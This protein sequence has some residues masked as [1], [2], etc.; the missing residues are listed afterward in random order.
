MSTQTAFDGAEAAGFTPA[1]NL[2]NVA[3]GTT[4]QA[5]WR[6]T[7]TGTTTWNGRYRFVYTLTPHPE[8]AANPRSPLGTQLVFA[9]T[10]LG[11]PAA[12]PPG[13]TVA[14][15][16]TLTAPA[17][18]ATHATNWQLQVPDGRR[19]SLNAP[20]TTRRIFRGGRGDDLTAYRCS[21]RGTLLPDQSG[22]RRNRHGFRVVLLGE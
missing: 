5:T 8:T 2:D 10:D 1:I 20:T 14:L 11:A 16:V 21:R 22:P 6:Y 15:T 4:F 19:D 13:E 7:N 3:P 18:A 12:V 17:T 9:I